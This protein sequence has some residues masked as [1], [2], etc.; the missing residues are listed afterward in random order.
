MTLHRD[1]DIIETPVDSA[2]VYDGSFL[3]VKRDTVRLPN[4]R[5]STREYIVHPGA[6]VIIALLDDDRVVMVRQYRH[7]LRRVITEFPAGKLDLG[8]SPL[9]CAQR[10]LLE[11]TGYTAERWS[12]AGEMHLA[13]GYSDEVIHIYFATG[14]TAGQSNPDEDEFLNVEIMT[15]ERLLEACRSGGITDAKSLSCALWLQNVRDGR[16]PILL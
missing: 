4:G 9:T 1:S 11:E 16:W 14:L 3:K 15:I 12:A 5:Q 7:P 10:E 13:V 2:S 8:E 6:V